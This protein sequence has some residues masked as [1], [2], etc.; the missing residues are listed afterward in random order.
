MTYWKFIDKFYIAK[1]LNEKIYSNI[2]ID[3][4]YM[5]DVEYGYYNVFNN[6]TNELELKIVEKN[7]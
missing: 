1:I 4:D 3:N 6:V 2:H 5:D 7:K